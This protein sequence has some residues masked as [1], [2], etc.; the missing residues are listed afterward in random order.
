MIEIKNH[1]KISGIIFLTHITHYSNIQNIISQGIL[2]HN[3]AYKG[4]LI[5][6]DISMES[7]QKRRDFARIPNTRIK[8]H[9]CASLY[10]NSRNPMLYKLKERQKE[11]VLIQVD[12]DIL[13]QANTYFTDGNAASTKTKF[14]N[15]IKDIDRLNWN[16]I[17]DSSWNHPD[18]VIHSENKRI[19]CAEV[20][21]NG[22]IENFQIFQIICYSN[23]IKE[24]IED[25]ISNH[26]IPLDISVIVDRRAYF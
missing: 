5:T 24:L 16:I 9:D 8:I 23:D 22:K 10:F 14:Y 6:Q 17:I 11:L 3:E 18:E 25:A 20:L 13:M 26:F 21:V 15:D 12:P 4:N 1:P 19:R 2:S 7:V